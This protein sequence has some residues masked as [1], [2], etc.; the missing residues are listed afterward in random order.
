M[1]DA[2]DEDYKNG[3]INKGLANGSISC[4][5][6]KGTDPAQ[7]WWRHDTGDESWSRPPVLVTTSAG[8]ACHTHMD[9]GSVIVTNGSRKWRSDSY[10]QEGSWYMEEL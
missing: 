10:G 4:A 2:W 9:G 8:P 5:T 6:K 3:H 7:T 1:A